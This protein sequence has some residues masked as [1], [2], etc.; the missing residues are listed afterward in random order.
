MIAPRG[1]GGISA[2]LV[3]AFLVQVVLGAQA[4]ATAISEEIRSGPIF[5]LAIIAAKQAAQTIKKRDSASESVRGLS[6]PS[7]LGGNGADRCDEVRLA[8]ADH[9]TF[10]G[11]R[12]GNTLLDLPPPA[13][14]SN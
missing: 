11:I 6:A 5:R 9:A 3:V 10:L 13:S 1:P 8:I 2:L 14:S 7:K 12:L 4:S